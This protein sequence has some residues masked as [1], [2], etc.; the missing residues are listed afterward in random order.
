MTV[1]Q[2]PDEP[3]R[4]SGFAVLD[5]WL[6]LPLTATD[7]APWR[8]NVKRTPPRVSTGDRGAAAVAHDTLIV[9]ATSPIDSARRMATGA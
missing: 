2:T 6:K 5:H 4:V 8:V 3:D 7:R 9:M 1:D